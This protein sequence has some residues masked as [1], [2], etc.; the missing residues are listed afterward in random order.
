ML[1]FVTRVH[2]DTKTILILKIKFAVRVSWP[3]TFFPM[4]RISFMWS[5]YKNV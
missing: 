4:Q 2:E 3:L 1:K 5:I